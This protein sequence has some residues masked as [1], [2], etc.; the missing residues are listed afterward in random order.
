MTLRC[1]AVVWPALL[2]GVGV[3]P[4]PAQTP[5][6][7][8]AAA[9]I[10][11]DRPAVTDSSAVVPSGVFQAENGVLDTDNQGQRTLD[12]PETLIRFGIGPSTELRFTAPDYFQDSLT[13]AGP[14]SGFGDLAVGVKQQLF[15][16]P[17]G[18]QVAA[19]VSLSFPTGAAAISS[20][21]YDPS[22]V[23]V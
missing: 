3:V 15:N 19:V 17:G 16:R 23:S 7:G 12:F 14:R 1:G 9:A 6:A 5:D 22:F 11:T 13:A 4:A 8:S 21:G 18:F 10:A 20:H 2:I